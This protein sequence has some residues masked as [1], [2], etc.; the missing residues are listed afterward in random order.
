[1]V[2][3]LV[4]LGLGDEED[5]TLRGL[6][7]VRKCETVYLEAY[8]SILTVGLNVLM[9][10]PAGALSIAASLMCMIYALGGVSGA[11]FNPAVLEL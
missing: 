8:T 11:N 6:N 3:W 10:S 1:M 4:G 7:V 2:F 9:K 5:I